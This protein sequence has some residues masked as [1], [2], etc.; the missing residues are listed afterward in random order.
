MEREICDGHF[1]QNLSTQ[2]GETQIVLLFKCCDSPSITSLQTFLR[3]KISFFTKHCFHRPNNPNSLQG[4]IMVGLVLA[5]VSYGFVLCVQE[6]NAELQFPH[7]DFITK[8]RR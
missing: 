2:S 8:F 1:C 4:C 5:G 6:W 3:S 7:F